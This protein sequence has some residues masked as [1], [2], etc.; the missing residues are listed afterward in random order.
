MTI[1][2]TAPLGTPLSL[3][4][5]NNEPS[6][7]RTF[8]GSQFLTRPRR[9]P[10]SID[11]TSQVALITGASGL[12]LACANHLLSMNLSH[13]IFGVRSVAKGEAAAKSLRSRYPRA[14]ID[15]WELEMGSYESITSF[16]QRADQQ[17]RRLDIVILNAAVMAK[18]FRLDPTTK[19]EEMVQVNYLSTMLL[20]VLLVPT[21]KSKSPP[22]KP[23]RLTIIS[24]STALHARFPDPNATPLLKSFDDAS[25]Q[26]WNFM[27]R[28][29]F[30]KLLGHFFGIKLAEHISSDDVIVNLVDPGFCRGSGLHRDLEGIVAGA[31]AMIKS[32]AGRSIENG[33]WTYVDAAV[34]KGPESHGSFIM[35]WAISP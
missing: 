21:L 13:L 8:I 15:V 3:T 14:Q 12:G 6:H 32:L 18:D 24:S 5:S 26:S 34:V 23:S 17:L 29:A 19:H 1:P 11:L 30:S 31:F 9:A 33:A 4:M 2:N 20:A 7:L 27:D 22:E 35:D 28:Y 16:A 10:P 25:I